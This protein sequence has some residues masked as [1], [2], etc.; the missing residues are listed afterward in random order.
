MN[1]MKQITSVRGAVNN[2]Y[3]LSELVE[4]RFNII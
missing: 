3:T 2:K 4:W 1:Y